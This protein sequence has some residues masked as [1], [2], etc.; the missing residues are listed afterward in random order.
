M[1]GDAIKA[2][3][4]QVHE[5]LLRMHKALIEWEKRRYEDVHGTVGSPYALLQLLI[6][7]AQFAWLRRMSELIVQ[8]DE[9]VSA[10]EGVV[11]EAGE[12]ILGQVREL[13]DVKGDGEFQGNYREAVEGDGEVAGLDGELRG[14]VG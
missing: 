3:L 8:I 2:R 10:K 5:V 14:V 13:I 6:N 9:V 4:N 12:A 11:V 7:D 1:A